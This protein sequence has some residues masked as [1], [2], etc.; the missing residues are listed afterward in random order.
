MWPTAAAERLRIDSP[1]I[2]APMGGGP[3]TVA[4]AAAVSN[5]GGLGSLAGGYLPPERL[6]DEIAQ[7]RAATARPFAV[8]LFVPSTIGDVAAE[9]AAAKR[10]LDP[11][12]AELG[13]APLGDFDR[14][15]EDFAAQLDVVVA[16]EVP[17][18]SYAFGMVAEADIARL[19]VAGTLVMG[20]ATNV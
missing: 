9:V 11:L 18:F 4:L 7:L 10:V 6:A 19:H 1:I 15:A 20:T 14:W 12:R 3:S 16:Q 5:A 8:N 2:Q 13:L 17:V